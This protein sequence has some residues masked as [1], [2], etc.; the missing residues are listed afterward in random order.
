MKS[1]LKRIVIVGASAAGVF[2]AE[3]L[4]RHGFNGEIV[5]T[6]DEPPYDRPPLSKQV[7][8]GHWEPERAT[9]MPPARMAAL[10]AE[11]LVNKRAVALNVADRSVSFADGSTLN[12]DA[13]VVATG[14]QPR[15]L[16]GGRKGSVHVLRTIDDALTLREGIRKYGEVVVIGAGFIGLE[17]AS[18]AALLGA[19]VKVV[20]P[21]VQ[22]LAS[23]IGK[24]A[25]SRLLRRHTEA[26]V[27]LKTGIGVRELRADGA[28]TVIALTDG[29]ELRS[30][31]VLVGIG[32]VPGVDW[33]ISSGLSID[34]GLI[35]DDYCMAGPNV[36][37]AG[38]V[39]RWYHAGLGRHLR[40]E[41]RTNA[42][43][44]GDVVA[45]NILGAR[46][47]FTPVPFFWSDQYE[48][49]LQCAGLLP[50]DPEDEGVLEDGNPE[51]ASYLRAFYRGGELVGVLG[52]NA[53]KAMPGYRRRMNFDVLSPEVRVT[54]EVETMRSSR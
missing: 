36:W 32:C 1:E 30:G 14:A 3:A 18:S 26:G 35:C 50:D 43:E 33:L 54:D 13:L 38:D 4:R 37:A 41:H 27:D 40:I 9:L 8:S 21:M 25:A 5:V 44:Q 48:V 15:K 28:D 34:N 39:A 11:L 24:H 42:Q 49:K 53:A 12:Y 52:W 29:S 51:G 46:T 6:G 20:E 16:P 17:V 7:L 19:R 31:C 10:D 2:T 22:P 47:R 45:R 23:R